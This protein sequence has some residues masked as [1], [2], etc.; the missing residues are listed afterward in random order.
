MN[1]SGVHRGSSPSPEQGGCVGEGVGRS[2]GLGRREQD[3][4]V[5]SVSSDHEGR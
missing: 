3:L 5:A 2:D 1:V 4:H